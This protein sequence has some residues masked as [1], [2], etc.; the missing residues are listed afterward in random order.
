MSYAGL[1][2]VCNSDPIWRVERRGDA[3][4]SW[5]CNDD[6]IFVCQDLQRDWEITELVVTNA[7]KIREWNEIAGTLADIT[8]ET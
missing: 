5:A 2:Q 3:A 6:L 7:V 4:V 8:A 1:C